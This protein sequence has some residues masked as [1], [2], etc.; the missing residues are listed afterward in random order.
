MAQ[1]I[2]IIMLVTQTGFATTEI[3]VVP[4]DNLGECEEAKKAM[5]GDFSKEGGMPKGLI[6]G[7]FYAACSKK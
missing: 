4:F 3:Q 6:S 1:M 5:V 7:R 2:I